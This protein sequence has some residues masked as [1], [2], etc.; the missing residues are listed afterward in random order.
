LNFTGYDGV[1]PSGAVLQA[2]KGISRGT[3][4]LRGRS[5]ASLV[6][7]RGFGMTPIAK[8]E[9][10]LSHYGRFGSLDTADSEG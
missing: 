4:Q 9:L 5:L 3:K 1:I 8:I 6:K 10:K 2:E 7:A